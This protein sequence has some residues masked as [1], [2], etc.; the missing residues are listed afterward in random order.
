MQIT[1][2]VG[3]ILYRMIDPPAQFNSPACRRERSKL[4]KQ[5]TISLHIN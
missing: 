4:E 5:Q 1:L 2:Y 3:N